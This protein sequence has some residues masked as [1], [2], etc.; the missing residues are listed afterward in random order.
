VAEC[1]GTGLL[2]GLYA[3]P[4]IERQHRVYWAQI[5]SKVKLDAILYPALGC[6]VPRIGNVGQPD[7]FY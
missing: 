1:A 5:F 6:E 4:E 7:I 2:E 3:G